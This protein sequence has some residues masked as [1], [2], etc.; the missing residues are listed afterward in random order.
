MS[1]I[2]YKDYDE[3]FDQVIV[4]NMDFE[5]YY[6]NEKYMF[7]D[8]PVFIGKRKVFKKCFSYQNVETHEEYKEK[9][10]YYDSWDDML[11]NCYFQDGIKLKDVAHK[12]EDF[13]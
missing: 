13:L 9:C 11:E 4:F 7:S 12:R 2:T 5:F 10:Q 3:F 6:K 8:E 1:Y